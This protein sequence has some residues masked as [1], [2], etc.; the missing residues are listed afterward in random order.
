[1]A[2]RADHRALVHRVRHHHAIALRGCRIRS[3]GVVWLAW[4]NAATAL[5]TPVYCGVTDL[6]ASFKID[7]RLTGYDR[8]CAWWAY[9][10]LSTL[11]SQRWGDMRKDVAAVLGPLQSTMFAQQACD[12]EGST[13]VVPSVAVRR[14]SIS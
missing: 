3:G 5:Y 2:G 4:D 8:R 14:G 10:H 7:G 9:N 11:A 12:G 6:P 13:A 1:M